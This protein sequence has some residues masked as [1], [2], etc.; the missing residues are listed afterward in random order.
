M[1]G[2]SSLTTGSCS[3]WNREK[4]VVFGESAKFQKAKKEKGSDK[5]AS[6][7]ND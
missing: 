6:L 2:R 5:D 3:H 4:M 7:N 1:G